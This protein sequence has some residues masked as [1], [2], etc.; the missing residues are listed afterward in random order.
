[1]KR[2]EIKEKTKTTATEKIMINIGRISACPTITT[3]Q[4]EKNSGD[5]NGH[6]DKQKESNYFQLDI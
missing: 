4:D 1:M 6:D 5:R 2:N 3:A